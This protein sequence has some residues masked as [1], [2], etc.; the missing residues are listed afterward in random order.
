MKKVI[1]SVILAASLSSAVEVGVLGLAGQNCPSG[2]KYDLYMLLNTE[3]NKNS[4]RILTGSDG[5]P[6]GLRIASKTKDLFMFYCIIDSR[7]LR[8]VPYDY[9]VLRYDDDC[10]NG[11]KKFR[12]HHD[13]EDSGYNSSYGSIWPSVVY[14]TV[15]NADLE[16][17][18][19]PATP[20]ATA[21]FPLDGKY[22]VFADYKNTATVARSVVHV[23]D[24]DSKNS[25]SWNW[26]GNTSD[27]QIRIKRI[28]QPVDE[29]NNGH[30]DTRYHVSWRMASL[31]KSAA[32]EAPVV[33]GNVAADKPVAAEVK[34]FDRS[35][36]TFEL[37]SAGNAVVS[38]VNIN[39]AVVAKVS[40]EN[41]QPGVHSVEWHS[42]IV[43][44]GRYVVTIEH[45]GVTSGKN[46]ILK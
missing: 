11:A 18:F 21:D 14:K 40:K 28:V 19:V 43:P 36:V 46:V 3:N 20:G 23:D 45:N 22:G 34:G 27:I 9:A 38:I 6:A 12:R 5:V 30:W 29:K 4:T 10:P 7:N 17:C 39:G 25:N 24:E 13:T 44:S 2:Q 41:L 32:A 8:P 35:A 33:A 15:E 16:F 42:G 26:Y 31:A 37:K 1:S